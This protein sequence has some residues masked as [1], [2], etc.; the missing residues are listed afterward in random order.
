MYIPSSLVKLG[1]NGTIS[2][3]LVCKELKIGVLL[4]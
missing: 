1:E 4:N 2:Y 3:W